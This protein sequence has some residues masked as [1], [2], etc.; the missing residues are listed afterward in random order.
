MLEFVQGVS[1]QHFINEL[2]HSLH[3]DR[4][5]LDFTLCH[6]IIASVAIG[7]GPARTKFPNI[8]LNGFKCIGEL[9]EMGTEGDVWL[10]GTMHVEDGIRV[11]IEDLFTHEFQC[12]VQPYTCPE[13]CKC[14]NEHI[15]VD[16][17]ILA[18]V[19]GT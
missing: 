15:G 12:L 18:L 11:V 9:S 6:I 5:T 13:G 7:F 17:E 3:I 1:T 19:L 2:R 10:I 4:V 16:I 14:R 8:L